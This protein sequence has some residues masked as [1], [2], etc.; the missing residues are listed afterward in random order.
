MQVPETLVGTRRRRGVWGLVKGVR[1][2]FFLTQCYP[3]PCGYNV[4]MRLGWPVEN[5][6]GVREFLP[7]RGNEIGIGSTWKGS[8]Q[9]SLLCGNARNLQ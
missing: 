3:V 7:E 6:V 9:R 5:A 4:L 1:H 2:A 8:K